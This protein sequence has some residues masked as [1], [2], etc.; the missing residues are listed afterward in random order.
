MAYRLSTHDYHCYTII[1]LCT[2]RIR[3]KLHGCVHCYILVHVCNVGSHFD[4]F[5]N[6]IVSLMLHSSCMID[7]HT[8]LQLTSLRELCDNV[9][10]IYNYSYT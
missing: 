7:V 4:D 5:V 8:L 9:V 3:T 2:K 6:C 1:S 10:Y